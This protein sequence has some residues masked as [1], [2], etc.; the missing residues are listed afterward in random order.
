M[1]VDL[2]IMEPSDLP[3]HERRKVEDA[4]AL[5]E[6]VLLTGDHRAALQTDLYI[7]AHPAL[8]QALFDRLGA[9]QDHPGAP[10]HVD[11]LVSY[12]LNAKP[13][14]R[15]SVVEALRTPPWRDVHAWLLPE[16]DEG[17]R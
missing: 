4:H 6:I 8:R 14:F 15:A 9:Q 10:P 13:A 2:A 1:E 16:L 17:E 7:K 3:S 11:R 5:G 12:R